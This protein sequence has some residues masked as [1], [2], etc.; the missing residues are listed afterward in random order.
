MNY[1]RLI[2]LLALLGLSARVSQGAPTQ[3]VQKNIT[4]QELLGGFKVPAGQVINFKDGGKIGF[5][6]DSPLWEID[7]QGAGTRGFRLFDTSGSI[8]LIVQ[9]ADGIEAGLSAIGA[10]GPL[11]IYSNSV[12]A[13]R[14]DSSGANGKIGQT[15]P[16]AGN[17]TDILSTGTLQST[18]I[19]SFSRAFFAKVEFLTYDL[20][21]IGNGGNMTLISAA[22]VY[23]VAC[24]G[25]TASVTLPTSPADG[26][27][28][29]NGYST[30]TGGRQVITVPA[31]IRPE[32]D[33]DTTQTTFGIAS[34]SGSYW[35]A[36]FTAVNGL[37]VKFS[38][39]GDDLA[40]T[41][42]TVS[43]TAYDQSTWDGV[44]TSAPSK[45]A[46][47]D[48]FESLTAPIPLSYLD[49]DVTAAANSNTKVMSQAAT[50]AL[51]AANAGGAGDSVGSIKLWSRTD[52]ASRPSSWLLCDGNN[53]TLNLADVATAGGTGGAAYIVKGYGSTVATPTFSPAAGTYGGPQTVT[54]AAAS[55][56]GISIK[57][58]TDGSTPSRS[59]GTD[60]V[61]PVSVSST[62]TLKAIAFRDL[63]V[64]SSVASGTYTLSTYLFQDDVEYVNNTAAGTPTGPWTLGGTPTFGDTTSP[65]AGTYSLQVNASADAV[66]LATPFAAQSTVWVYFKVTQSSLTN[67]GFRVKFLNA[68]SAELGSVAVLATSGTTR[69]NSSGGSGTNTDTVGAVAAGTV[70]DVWMSY[71][72][73]GSS[74]TTTLYMSTGTGVKGTGIPRTGTST[75]NCTN[76]VFGA[77]GSTI[78][79]YDKIRI[80]N[81]TIAD[82][83]S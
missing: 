33:P 1:F 18:G 17:F 49:T 58:T 10:S 45:N 77:A 29:I 24:S 62:S 26:V 34:S 56:S 79:L 12:E 71:V 39:D 82:N 74:S 28:K 32:Q 27:Y 83:P 30:Y 50:V 8:A 78:I 40:P 20:G 19:A 38:V 5:N 52:I 22:T 42:A 4:T 64:D 59:V 51:I 13:M 9:T 48:K 31:L 14:F 57:Y 16:A 7:D 73:T 81:T 54:I 61:S 35:T 25:A 76:I 23:R 75:A 72:T 80:S 44:T 6:T 11:A 66:S 21:T 46:V 53:G 65:L 41:G 70:Y 37:F 15:T 69:L 43:D 67:A 36:V 60:Y 3:A 55:P 47:R 2:F 63:Y 68:S